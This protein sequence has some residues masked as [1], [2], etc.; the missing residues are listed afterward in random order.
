MRDFV[1]QCLSEGG[2]DGINSDFS[3]RELR[4]QLGDLKFRKAVGADFI[5]NELL[6]HLP[7]ES[8][9]FILRLFNSSW[10]LGHEPAT[11]KLQHIIPILKPGKDPSVP[12][13]YR[14][15][16]LTSCFGKLMEKMV[17][18]RLDWWL[19]SCNLLPDSQCGFRKGRGTV[20]NLLQLNT[21]SLMG[22]RRNL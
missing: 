6:K 11:W 14:P 3:M 7:D 17:Q 16:S 4:V 1:L 10:S 9:P 12:A 15:I 2:C 19:E 22:L 5:A 21:T 18:A 20:D 13:S 8:L